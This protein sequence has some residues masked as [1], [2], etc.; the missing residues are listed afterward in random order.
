MPR[1]FSVPLLV[2]CKMGPSMVKY[3][4]VSI[5]FSFRSDEAMFD[6]VWQ[7]LVYDLKSISVKVSKELCINNWIQTE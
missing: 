6:F 4:L 1:E 5:T 3:S 2:M 7:K